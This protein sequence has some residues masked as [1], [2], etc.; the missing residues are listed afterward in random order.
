MPV[1]IVGANQK[2]AI[3]GLRFKA[4]GPGNPIPAEAYLGLSFNDATAAFDNKYESF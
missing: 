4:S 2:P 3:T 1:K